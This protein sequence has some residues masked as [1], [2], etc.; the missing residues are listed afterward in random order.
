MNDSICLNTLVHWV[1]TRQLHREFGIIIQQYLQIKPLSLP[2]LKEKPYQPKT[3]VTKE[4]KKQINIQIK[5]HQY[6]KRENNF[7]RKIMQ[8]KTP[9]YIQ[10]GC[11][12][13]LLSDHSK[14]INSKMCL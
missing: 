5:P 3:V 11:S 12:K 1:Q 7:K 6:I 8:K 9:I 14:S 10:T 4:T 2:L 13:P